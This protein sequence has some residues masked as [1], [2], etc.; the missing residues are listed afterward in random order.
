MSHFSSSSLGHFIHTLFLFLFLLLSSFF[1]SLL[2]GPFPPHAEFTFSSY[3]T[4]VLLLTTLKTSFSHCLL[5]S[6]KMSPTGKPMLPV[7]VCERQL[8]ALDFL[9]LYYSLNTRISSSQNY[10]VNVTFLF[11][12]LPFIEIFESPVTPPSVYAR[13]LPLKIT[14]VTKIVKKKKKIC[15]FLLSQQANA[16]WW[17]EK[18]IT[19]ITEVKPWL[20]WINWS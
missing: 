10:S 8:V 2:A 14:S 20:R 7:S 19:D 12:K 6:F 18:N 3:V 16:L 15:S 1:C 11:E 13:V 4:C 5:S 9:Y 17:K